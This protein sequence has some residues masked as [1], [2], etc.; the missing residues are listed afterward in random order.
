M[1]AGIEPAGSPVTVK[2]GDFSSPDAPRGTGGPKS[3]TSFSTKHFNLF[4]C[5]K[6]QTKLPTVTYMP[7]SSHTLNRL[8]QSHTTH[9]ESFL[10]DLLREGATHRAVDSDF[11]IPSDTERSHGVTR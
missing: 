8:R 6:K 7:G 1:S 3:K 5:R 9:L 10:E 4:K 2:H 11:L